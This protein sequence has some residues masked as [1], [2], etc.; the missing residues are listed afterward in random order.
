MQTHA[1]TGSRAGYARA[2]RIKQGRSRTDLDVSQRG[3]R[4]YTLSGN[5]AST[6]PRLD[7]SYLVLFLFLF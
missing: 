4:S 6:P 2:R 5:R 1:E 3:Y 7:Q